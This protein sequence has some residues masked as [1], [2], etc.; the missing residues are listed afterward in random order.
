M[1]E[2]DD[3]R[4]ARSPKRNPAKRPPHNGWADAFQ[5]I[6]EAG[7]DELVW[8]EFANAGDADLR[9]YTSYRR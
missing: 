2:I 6:A 3:R 1:S 9:W 7:D 4:D 5:K 8:P